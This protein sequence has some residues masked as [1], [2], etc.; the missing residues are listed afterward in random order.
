MAEC[1][2]DAAAGSSCLYAFP[3]RQDGRSSSSTQCLEDA[4]ADGNCL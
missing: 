2:R 1:L 4:A 3:E